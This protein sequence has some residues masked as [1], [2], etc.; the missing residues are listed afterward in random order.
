MLQSN[1][2]MGRWEKGVIHMRWMVFCLIYMYANL[3]IGLRGDVFVG[4]AE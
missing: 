2:I 3:E 4:E 1:E